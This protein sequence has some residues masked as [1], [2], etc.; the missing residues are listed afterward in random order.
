M[1]PKNCMARD[2]HRS[3]TNLF[4]GYGRIAADNIVRECV[5]YSVAFFQ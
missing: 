4:R 1:V 2:V 5:I 3:R